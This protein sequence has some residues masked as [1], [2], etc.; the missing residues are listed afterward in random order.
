M[1]GDINPIVS[2]AN[3]FFAQP[4]ALFVAAQGTLG[5]AQVSIGSDDAV[6]R[7]G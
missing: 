2:Q 1:T 6:P 7:Q 4:L 5:Q 3:A